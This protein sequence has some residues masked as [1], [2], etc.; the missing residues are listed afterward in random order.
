[1]CVQSVKKMT[2]C[3]IQILIET[4]PRIWPVTSLPPTL[5]LGDVGGFENRP[6]GTT[7]D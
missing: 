1:M 4:S 3:S 7:A 5:G 6:P 2:T